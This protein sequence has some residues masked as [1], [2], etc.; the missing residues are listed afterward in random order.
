M[1]RVYSLLMPPDT[2]IRAACE[3]V[4]CEYWRDGWDSPVDERTAEGQTW[5]RLIRHESGRTF[6]EL[7][8]ADGV[9]V[10]R[11]GP[12]QRCF[13]EH[14]TRPGRYLVRGVREH[15]SLGDWIEDIGEHV[16]SIE[17]LKKRG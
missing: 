15:S 4:G 16:T 1:P 9:T 12:G 11:F 6:R 13:R 2:T 10:F 3:D 5:A 7:R 17:D 14:R 8:R